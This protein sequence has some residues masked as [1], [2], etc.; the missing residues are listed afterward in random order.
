MFKKSLIIIVFSL[1]YNLNKVNAEIK[2]ME[3]QAFRNNRDFPETQESRG[4]FTVT[5]ASNTVF[6]KS[7]EG[8]FIST[9]KKNQ[10]N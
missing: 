8:L 10:K 3:W 9:Y 7:V 4:S 6:L 1:N 5:F 2:S